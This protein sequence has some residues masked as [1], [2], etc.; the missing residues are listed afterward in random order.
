MTGDY[1]VNAFD[2]LT[3][4][5]FD[6]SGLVGDPIF[7]ADIWYDYETGWDGAWAEI[8]TDGGATWNQLG[9]AAD[10]NWYNATLPS[11]PY[12]GTDSWNGF[13]NG[14][15]NVS[16]ELTGMAGESDVKIRFVQG[17][18]GSIVFDGLGVDNINIVEGCPPS[19]MLASTSTPELQAGAMDGTV[20]IM[21]NGG[22]APYM[23]MWST[24]DTTAMVSG[25]A[26]GTYHVTVTDA[27]GCTDTDSV[28]VGTFCPADLGLSTSATDENTPGSNDGTATVTATGGTSPY[29]Y[30]WDN[31]GIMA[32]I[33]G[34]A[35]GTYHVTVSD[36]NGCTDTDSVVV[37]TLC[38]TDLG[39]DIGSNPEIGDG[40]A[41]GT[42]TVSASAG[43]APYTYLWSN[44]STNQSATGL[45][46]DSTTYSVTVT[47]ANGCTDV[48]SVVVMTVYLTNTENISSLSN[49][50]LAPNPT[51]DA[52]NLKLTFDKAVD[53]EVS[54]VDA[55]GRVL[56]T[57][58]R[59]NATNVDYDFDL[60]DYPGGVYFVRISADNQ[61][62][63]KRIVLMK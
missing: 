23:Y 52:T 40:N 5:C 53:V 45:T 42:A 2:A 31:G 29:G 46:G 38:P 34:L 15:V 54:I 22:I 33:T 1:S 50:F 36:A 47:D 59:S 9:S 43:A 55:L 3:S 63:A 35:P 6:F 30:T 18:D 26:A 17:S 37:G 49:L 44:G 56:Q 28:T 4:P 20:D 7:S 57:R 60:S 12:V 21:A 58:N 48:A 32:T 24:M 14:W 25:L 16:I 41:D 13:S 19:L 39:L 62:M 61:V 51:H 27:N 11:G 8:S 10:P